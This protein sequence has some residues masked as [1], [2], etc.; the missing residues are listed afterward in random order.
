MGF[1]TANVGTICHCVQSPQCVVNIGLPCVRIDR[2][3]DRLSI[4]SAALLWLLPN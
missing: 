1:I 2:E 3:I 4:D